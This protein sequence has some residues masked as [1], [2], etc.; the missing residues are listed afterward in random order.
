LVKHNNIIDDIILDL[1]SKDRESINRGINRINKISTEIREQNGKKRSRLKASVNE[2][3][4]RLLL[5]TNDND[6]ETRCTALRSL[7][8]I[9]TTRLSENNLKNIVSMLLKRITDEDGRVRW[10]TVQTLDW[11]KIFL[12][13]E[14]Y[15]ET[16]L[17]LQEKYG[18]ETGGVSKSIGQ[19]LKRMD[20]PYYRLM[21][22]AKE[23]QQFGAYTKEDEEAL[24]LEAATKGI[25]S[26]AEE[27]QENITRRRLKMTQAPITPE[28]SLKETFSRYNKDALEAMAK[29][30]DLPTPITGLKKKQLI[31]KISNNLHNTKVLKKVVK[32]LNPEESLALL[33]LLHKNG[34]MPRNRFT[35]KYGNDTHES[36]YWKW[37]PP[38]SIIGRLKMRGLVIEGKYNEKIWIQVPKE[39]IPQLEEIKEQI[40]EN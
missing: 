31:E 3:V 1:R 14:L 28:I 33:D 24:A 7:K 17:K 30:L 4:R 39:L 36:I 21:L 16:Y 32:D 8:M 15:H 20:S 19:A 38:T 6:W 9:Y 25:K 23:Y 22:K 18:R 5:L 26:L 13:P 10:A 37:H 29:T 35:E 2:L 27:I 11:L 34:I 12:P 40:E